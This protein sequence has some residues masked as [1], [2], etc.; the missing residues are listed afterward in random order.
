MIKKIA[1]KIYRSFFSQNGSQHEESLKGGYCSIG[2]NTVFNAH[3]QLELRKPLSGKVF[4]SVGNESLIEGRFVFEK[5]TGCIEIGDRVFIGGGTTF[6]CIE[7]IKVDD[8]VMFSWGCTIVDNNAHSIVSAERI[9]D[10]SDWKR[11]I[12]ENK[13][14]AYKN[15]DVVKSAPVHIKR[16]A[17]IGFNSIILKGVTIG[18]GAVVGAGSVVTRDVPDFAVV[19]G[20]PATII[21]YTT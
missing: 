14:G 6:I 12:A 9:S 8:D 4:L 10:V 3:H 1:R 15:W 19:G 20:N 7:G 2:E 11:G 16:K 18:E 17:W 13:T 5:D 21:K